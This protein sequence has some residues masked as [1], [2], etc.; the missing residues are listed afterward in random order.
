MGCRWGGSCCGCCCCCERRDRERE[1]LDDEDDDEDDDDE[2]D[3]DDDDDE[4]SD[5]D[6]DGVLDVFASAII[7]FNSPSLITSFANENEKDD[8]GSFI[9]SLF[10]SDNKNK[11]TLFKKEK[12]VYA[13]I[14]GST[15]DDDMTL[16]KLSTLLLIDLTIIID[17]TDKRWTISSAIAFLSLTLALLK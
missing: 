14:L 12:S 11:S 16:K 13:L 2:D 1:D 15:S 4:D 17:S 7:W 6:S 5:E 9:I 8:D 10:I 3:D